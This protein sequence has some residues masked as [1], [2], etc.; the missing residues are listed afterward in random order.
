VPFQEEGLRQPAQFGD[1]AAQ[2]GRWPGDA[3]RRREEDVDGVTKPAL[4]RKNDDHDDDEHPEG[5]QPG[6]GTAP[7]LACC[8]LSHFRTGT[9]TR[10]DDL[11]AM[12]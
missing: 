2:R 1:E 6:T 9:E 11:L 7:G 4:H 10:H 5:A 8:Q 3:V 12:G